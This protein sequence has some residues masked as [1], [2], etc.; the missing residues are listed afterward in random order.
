METSIKVDKRTQKTPEQ[1][2]T[3]RLAREKAN[4]IRSERSQVKKKVKELKELSFQKDKDLIE[5]MERQ[6][7]QPK[8]EPESE[9]EPEPPKVKPK[10]PKKIV[11]VSDSSEEEIE[12][13]KKVKPPK[14]IPIEEMPAPV[15]SRI[16]AQEHIRRIQNQRM[17]SMLFGGR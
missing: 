10:K 12:Y 17:R 9:P 6:L 16:E 11:Y 3:L 7:N 13:V 5:K 8:P 1:L 14:K 4:A 15:M 2:E